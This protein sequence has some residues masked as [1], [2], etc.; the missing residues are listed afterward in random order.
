[1]ISWGYAGGACPACEID[2]LRSGLPGPRG[3]PFCL[4]LLT[5][6]YIVVTN[7]GSVL[8][9][10][11]DPL[12]FRLKNRLQSEKMQGFLP[13]ESNHLGTPWCLL[14][15]RGP[16]HLIESLS[17]FREQQQKLVQ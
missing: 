4:V 11:V 10:K 5:F 14:P 6:R 16:M 3:Q 8:L 2:E 17:Q 12:G 1:M 15:D 7:R 9:S 13:G